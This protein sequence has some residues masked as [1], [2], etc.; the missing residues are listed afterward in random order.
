MRWN[1][2]HDRQRELFSD[3]AEPCEPPGSTRELDERPFVHEENEEKKERQ[4]DGGRTG[5]EVLYNAES[6]EQVRLPA[7]SV[8]IT[9]VD[10]L[11]MFGAAG[12]VGASN[13]G[14]A[15]LLLEDHEENTSPI[16]VEKWNGNTYIPVMRA[17]RVES[18]G[19]GPEARFII[20]SS[21]STEAKKIAREVAQRAENKARTDGG[22]V[23]AGRLRRVSRDDLITC[24]V[25]GQDIRGRV[26]SIDNSPEPAVDILED[27]FEVIVETDERK[28]RLQT[29]RRIGTDR[30]H[31]ST[32]SDEG[33][34]VDWKYIG[35]VED[36]EVNSG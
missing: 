23:P 7:I 18:C 28:Y 9:V 4:T 29:A 21:A 36:F 35:R 34:G 25:D 14:E 30:V 12:I 11:S 22:L 17:S 1:A 27:P 13:T 24:R 26:V 10:R 19:E 32:E 31:L 20:P 3:D 8:T 2:G 33:D 16:R 15:Y 6:F 5:L